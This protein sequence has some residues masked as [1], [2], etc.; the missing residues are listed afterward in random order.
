LSTKKEN[1][2][3]YKILQILKKEQKEIENVRLKRK[4]TQVSFT[5][6]ARPVLE[7]RL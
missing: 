2:H 6:Q 4:G 7:D 5:L 1:K 3:I